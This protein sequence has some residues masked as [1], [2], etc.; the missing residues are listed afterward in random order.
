[1]KLDGARSLDE[2]TL[3]RTQ[4]TMMEADYTGSNQP[5]EEG[6]DDEVSFLFPM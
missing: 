3:A 1:M 5:W 4:T 2:R 6:V